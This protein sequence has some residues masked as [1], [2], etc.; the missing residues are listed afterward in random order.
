MARYTETAQLSDDYYFSE[1]SE[2][3]WDAMIDYVENNSLMSSVVEHNIVDISTKATI[4]TQ[5]DLSQSDP[6]M[7][8]VKLMET[9][10]ELKTQQKLLVN[11]NNWLIHEKQTLNRELGYLHRVLSPPS[12]QPLLCFGLLKVKPENQQPAQVPT[13]LP[14]ARAA[15]TASS[16]QSETL[17]STVITTPTTPAI[18]SGIS[19][20][21]QQLTEMM[22]DILE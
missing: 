2:D 6:S 15:T 14:G 12:L 7:T 17:K 1:S 5:T 13:G 10:I 20:F 9:I 4:A 22:L 11:E 3:E 16:Y 18:F 8:N 19:F 21:I